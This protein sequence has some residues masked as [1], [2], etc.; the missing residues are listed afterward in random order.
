MQFS[1]TL[2]QQSEPFLCHYLVV[3]EMLNLSLQIINHCP[4]I[5][6]LSGWIMNAGQP[7]RAMF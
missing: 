2:T 4:L 6:A 5:P 1:N 7:H 3:L